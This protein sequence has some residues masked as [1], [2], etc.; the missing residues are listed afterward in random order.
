MNT[1]QT[2]TYSSA[3]SFG[4]TPAA[5]LSTTAR[6]T[7]AWAGPNIWTACL[8]P[9]IGTLVIITVAGL[10]SRF[11]VT[12]AIKLECPALWF[13]RALANATPTGPALSPIK[14]SMC[15]T[16]LPSP[17]RASPMYM[18]MERLLVESSERN[19]AGFDGGHHIS[20]KC[21]GQTISGEPEPHRCP[22]PKNRITLTG[23]APEW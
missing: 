6:A 19:G 10:A 16:S 23:P 21:D 4:I 5:T 12:T 22:A 18:A 3:L 15:D 17:T 13:A 7:A 2:I 14:R 11:G 1:P 9:L 20:Q 8:A